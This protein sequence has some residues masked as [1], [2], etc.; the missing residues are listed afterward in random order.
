MIAGDERRALKRY[1][2]DQVLA[3]R[4]TAGRATTL[5]TAHMDRERIAAS[6]AADYS[7]PAADTRLRREL[8]TAG[9]RRAALSR[10]AIA[11]GLLATLAGAGLGFG[12]MAFEA[13]VN[14]VDYTTQSWALIAP[15]WGALAALWLL[16][17]R[18]PVTAA[19][20][21]GALAL[22]AAY[23]FSDVYGQYPA[24]LVVLLAL[25]LV[26]L[27]PGERGDDGGAWRT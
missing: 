10:M 14:G 20:P 25:P 22:F 5:Y 15:V 16:V 17:R 27:P 1:G 8:T 3:R 26:L 2:A 23:Y 6:R 19:L 24:G 21:F 13:I 4:R 7:S 18:W 12:I 11:A 9:I